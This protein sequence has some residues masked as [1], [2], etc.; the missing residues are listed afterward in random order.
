MP[1]P[2]KPRPPKRAAGPESRAMLE[3]RSVD[4]GYGSFQAL[5]D[6]NLDVRGGEAVGVTGPNGAGKTPL[7]R[8]VSGL[9][10][11]SRGSIR[12]ERID[13]LARRRIALSVSA[14]RTCRRTEDCSRSSRSTTI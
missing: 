5:F 3:L 8:V 10:R 6:V 2:P 14:S 4:A 12:M 13:I 11:P 9:I 1:K 7:M